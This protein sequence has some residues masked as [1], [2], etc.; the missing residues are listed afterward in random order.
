MLSP[1]SHVPL[2]CDP[3]DC[4][5]PGSSVYGILQGRILEWVAISSSR[6]SF[7]HQ[8]RTQVSWIGGRFFTSEPL[9]IMTSSKLESWVSPSC[10]APASFPLMMLP[11]S[12]TP[13]PTGLLLLFLSFQTQFIASLLQKD[14]LYFPTL[15]LVLRDIYIVSFSKGAVRCPCRGW[16]SL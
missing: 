10:Y 2:M 14:F 8:D 4:S 5:P 9:G 11:S 7:Q 15:D 1:F 16:P 13:S 6:G 12:H 3:T